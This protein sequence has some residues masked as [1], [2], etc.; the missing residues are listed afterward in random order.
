MWCLLKLH[1][2]RVAFGGVV[3]LEELGGEEAEHAGENDVRENFAGG[4]IEL[5]AVVVG[6]A[7]EGDFVLGRRQLFG[8]LEHVLVRF[9]IRIL[10]GDDHEAAERAAEAGFGGEEAF[11]GVGVGGIGR[12]GLGGGGGD[13]AGFDDG[14]ERGALVLHVAF[15]DLDEIRN[16]VVAALELDVD[17]REGV[18]EAVTE[19]DEFVVDAGDPEA[20]DEKERDENTE[21][22]ECGDHGSEAGELKTRASVDGELFGASGNW[23]QRG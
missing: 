12:D 11:H 18:L 10:L 23:L 13:V 20:E 16:E 3:Y 15:G 21:G 6:L 4:I 19:F 17:L 5:D 2:R 7:G 14:F 9:E 8:E 1:L 22:D